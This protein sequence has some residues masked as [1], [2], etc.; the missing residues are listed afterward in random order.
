LLFV[1]IGFDVVAYA[2]FQHSM[3]ENPLVTMVARVKPGHDEESAGCRI[4]GVWL[5]TAY[6]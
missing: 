1:A 2:E 6:L 4:D 5:S 3:G